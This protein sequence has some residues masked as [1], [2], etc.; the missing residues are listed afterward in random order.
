MAATFV[1][2]FGRV[3]TNLTSGGDGSFKRAKTETDLFPKTDPKIDGDDC[4]HDC[5]SCSVK[6]P[7]KWSIDEEVELYGHVKG[8]HRHLIAA[9]GKTD[10][11]S[12]V[13]CVRENG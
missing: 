9:T 5:D 4:L 12:C 10:W 1:N 2:L 13:L 3:K 6:L 7:R 8:W 11:V